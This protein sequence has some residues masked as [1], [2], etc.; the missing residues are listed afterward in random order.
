MDRPNQDPKTGISYG[1]IN[2]CRVPALYE[3]LV[4]HGQCLTFD[5]W[6]KEETDRLA[7]IKDEYIDS[8]A[9]GNLEMF[10]LEYPVEIWEAL[11]AEEELEPDSDEYHPDEEVFYLKRKDGVI[12]QTSSGGDIW[13]F[14][15]PW[16]MSCCPC[17]PCVPGGGDL[18]TPSENGI[19]A[20]C[21]PPEDMPEEFRP[22]IRLYKPEED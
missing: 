13:C 17:S 5:A 11:D 18:N 9:A 4:V 16:V 20:Y 3:D 12:L 6:V 21:P 10:R 8:A 19:E 2:A 7:K 1:L 14:M 22:Y 15:S